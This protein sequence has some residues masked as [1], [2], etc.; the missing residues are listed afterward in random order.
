V[1]WWEY[2]R[3]LL[4]VKSD[5]YRAISS[6]NVTNGGSRRDRVFA[7]PYAEWNLLF[8][9]VEAQGTHGCAIN[10]LVTRPSLGPYEV[11]S[12]TSTSIVLAMN[13]HVAP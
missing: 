13:K 9:D 5:G 1:A 6:L 8:R 10:N 3:S 12:A 7:T 11:T 4:S 2:A